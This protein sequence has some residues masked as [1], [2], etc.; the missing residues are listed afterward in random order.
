M[1]MQWLREVAEQG[2][3]DAQEF[4]GHGYEHGLGVEVNAIEAVKW[5]R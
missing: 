5:N 4:V 2:N 1:T 3:A